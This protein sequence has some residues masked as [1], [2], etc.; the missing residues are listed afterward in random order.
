[1][2][3]LTVAGQDRNDVVAGICQELRCGQMQSIE[4]AHGRTEHELLCPSQRVAGERRDADRAIISSVVAVRLEAFRHPILID[5][6]VSF[7]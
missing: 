6:A 3:L 5:A 2:G 4:R 1:M 7:R